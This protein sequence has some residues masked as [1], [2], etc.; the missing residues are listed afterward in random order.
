[1]KNNIYEPFSGVRKKNSRL[2]FLIL[3]I[4]ICFIKLND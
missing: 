2:I 4:T 3:L 1:M